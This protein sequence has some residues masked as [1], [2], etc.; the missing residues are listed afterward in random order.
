MGK[1]WLPD[2]EDSAPEPACV[3]VRRAAVARSHLIKKKYNPGDRGTLQGLVARADLNNAEATVVMP[4]DAAEGEG[5]R[6]KGRVKVQAAGECLA[7]KYSN[8]VMDAPMSG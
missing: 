4:K 5:L 8:L 6:S 7:V 3:Q 1:A 2:F